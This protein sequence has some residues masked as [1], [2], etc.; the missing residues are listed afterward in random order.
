MTRDMSVTALFLPNIA[1][2]VDAGS[3]QTITLPSTVTL[4]GSTT[5]DG[6]PYNS[7]TTT[8]SKVSGSGN[9]TFADASAT[10]TTATFSGAGTYVLALVANDGAERATSTVT[11]TVNAAVTSGGGGGGGGGSGGGGFITPT[12]V[13]PLATS[14]TAILTNATGTIQ[15]TTLLSHTLIPGMRSPDNIT[16]QKFLY[17]QGKT[18]YATPTYSENYGP[19]TKAGVLAFQKVHN[20]P[21]TSIVDAKTLALINAIAGPQAVFVPAV[22]TSA[23]GTLLTAIDVKTGVTHPN[24]K[25]LQQ[26]LNRNGFTVATKGAGSPGFETTYFGPATTRAVILFQRE[27]NIYPVAGYVGPL[28][29]AKINAMISSGK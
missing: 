16:L 23:S 12:P 27:Y 9:V 8:W 19:L 20:L 13:Q 25:I 28:T 6:L 3:N 5:D 22:L 29:R 1:P 24:V 26:F 14:T 21:L 18:I 2:I 4:T 15:Y 11:I 17:S 7:L 10:S